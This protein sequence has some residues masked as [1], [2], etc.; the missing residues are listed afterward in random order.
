MKTLSLSFELENSTPAYGG[1]ENAFNLIRTRSIKK[2]DSSNNSF[3]KFNNHLGTH[4]DFPYHFSEHG[5]KS[6][7]YSPDFWVVNH[8]GFLECQIDEIDEE[9]KT[10]SNKIEFLI[11]KTGFSKFRNKELFWKDQP[12]IPSKLADGSTVSFFTLFFF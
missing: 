9:I 10:L 6:S 2:G 8:V 12:V 4:I 7:D 3:L 5:K 1:E 11:I